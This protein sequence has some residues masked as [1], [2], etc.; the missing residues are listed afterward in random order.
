MPGTTTDAPAWSPTEIDCACHLPLHP[1]AVRGIQLFNAGHYFEAH[2][3]LETAWRAEPGPQRDLYRAILLAGVALLHIQRG[4]H[5]GAVKVAQ[6]ALRWLA[7]YPESCCGVQLG[8]LRREMQAILARLLEQ[9]GQNLKAFDLS[10]IS[11][12]R[13]DPSWPV[14]DPQNF[15]KKD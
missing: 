8:S 3:A 7:C 13:Y 11:P 2:E 15:S 14:I 9:D 5:A 1:Q 6:R 4:N 12:I 10:I